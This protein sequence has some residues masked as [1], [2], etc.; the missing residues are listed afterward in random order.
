ME[1]GWVVGPLFV[2]M[3]Y[4]HVQ[5]LYAWLVEVGFCIGKNCEYAKHRAVHVE[6]RHMT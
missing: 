3:V 1:E 4:V 5:L 2:G 6:A